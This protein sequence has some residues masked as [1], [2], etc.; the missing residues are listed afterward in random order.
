[1]ALVISTSLYQNGHAEYVNPVMGD[2]TDAAY[3]LD[4]GGLYATYGNLP[5]AVKAYK[6]ALAID[7]ADSVIY[8]NLSLAYCE[9]DHYDKAL[10]AARKA[11]AM[12][13]QNGNYHYGLGWILLRTGKTAEAQIQFRQAADLTD[14][15]A[16]E[17]L[18]QHH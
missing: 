3:W 7:Q 18:K 15:D 9:M 10:I 6:K 17:Y 2:D 16:I 4:R 12:E 11:L 8:Y 14:Q 1:M 13:P 5:A